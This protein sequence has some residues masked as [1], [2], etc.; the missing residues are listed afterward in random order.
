MNNSV[1]Y[2]EGKKD[3]FNEMIDLI[4]DMSNMSAINTDVKILLNDYLEKKVN[5][6]DYHIGVILEN[7]LDKKRSIYE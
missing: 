2:Y 4:N 7:M 5:Y 3:A 1:E 6:C